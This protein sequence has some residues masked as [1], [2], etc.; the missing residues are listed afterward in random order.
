MPTIVS[1]T[2]EAINA[3]V[4]VLRDQI[5]QKAELDHQHSGSDVDGATESARGTVELATPAETVAG[6]DYTRATTPA[7]VKALADLKAA[8]GHGHNAIDI[9]GL[10]DFI[11]ATIQ[12]GANVTKNW[13]PVTKK[14]TINATGGSTGG[15]GTDAEVVRDTIQ[16][17]LRGINGINVTSNPNDDTDNTITLSISNVTQAQVQ[18]LATALA[19]KAD[20]A[21]THTAG[22]VTSG[23]FDPS[24][25][26]TGT[27]TSTTVLH[28]DG[29][30]R[31]PASTGGGT[32][33][34]TRRAD[35]TVPP[36]G[37]LVVDI[38]NAADNELFVYQN[39]T[40]YT[41]W[42]WTGLP[43]NKA[44]WSAAISFDGN[45]NGV[46][47]DGINGEPIRW[48]TPDGSR[49]LLPKGEVS[50][51]TLSYH[52][53]GTTG[54]LS[55]TKLVLTVESIAGKSAL[56][57][58]DGVDGAASSISGINGLGPLQDFTAIV[59]F[60]MIM[61]QPAGSTP[62]TEFFSLTGTSGSARM[63]LG[64]GTAS[65]LNQITGRVQ[66][67]G[68]SAVFRN[69]YA[70]LARTTGRHVAIIRTSG[71]RTAYYVHHDKI[72]SPT[73][74]INPLGGTPVPN[75]VTLNAGFSSGYLKAEKLWLF[76][77]DLGR[78]KIDA[79]VDRLATLNGF[80]PES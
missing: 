3:L 25:L 42:E 63:R 20:L 21:H 45:G 1:L 75:T 69:G 17:A 7:G 30:W 24:R 51:L 26:G 6:L 15:T 80:T 56:L 47:P 10:A 16:A 9:N 76:T 22:A 5:R 39:N 58:L 68:M 53:N 79:I 41:S 64:A 54:A 13:D 52:E 70:S 65:T 66:F 67:D 19:A 38:G 4:N 62:T 48:M 31:T 35:I 43:A 37:V 77:E 14:L 12:A 36:G 71:N 50:V 28:G 44:P 11:D 74:P 49:P 78:E 59:L 60:N 34:G 57:T 40:D 18:G 32:G 72:L 73:Q 2:T 33:T 23:V 46:L 29:V 55:T 27:P 61:A 8:I